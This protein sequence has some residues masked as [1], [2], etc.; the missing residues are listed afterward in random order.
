MSC[1]SY[2]RKRKTCHSLHEARNVLAKRPTCIFFLELGV[3]AFE[4]CLGNFV[5]SVGTWI[6]SV[7]A[8]LVKI[9]F[10]KQPFIV[11]TKCHETMGS[12]E[13]KIVPLSL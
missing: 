5:M 11:P 1:L 4:Q 3:Q 2:C 8:I 12:R 7:L 13:N 10:T 9:Q 6:S